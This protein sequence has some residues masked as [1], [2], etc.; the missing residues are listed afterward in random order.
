MMLEQNTI[1]TNCLED[2]TSNELFVFL[3]DV[4]KKELAIYG[5][6]KKFLFTEKKMILKAAPLQQ[7]NENNAVKENLILKAR[8]LEEG[9][10]NILKKIARSLD[11]DEK[12]IKLMSLANHASFEQRKAI[13]ELKYELTA[14]ADDIRNKN[15]EN[16][17]LLNVS[18]NNVNETLEFISSLVNR[19]GVYLENGKIGEVRKNGSI[20]RTEG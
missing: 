18:I 8:I 17:Y 20:V 16:K 11:I 6:L 5:E 4:L 19:S 1:V 14:V 13:E 10:I 7:L 15:D 9:R 12:G 3:I 2:S